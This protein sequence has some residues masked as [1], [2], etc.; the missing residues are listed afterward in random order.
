MSRK[1][2]MVKGQMA[3]IEQ[4]KLRLSSY[5]DK[6]WV[7]PDW[8]HTELCEFHM[9]WAGGSCVFVETT[10]SSSPFPDKATFRAMV[11]IIDDRLARFGYSMS[12]HNVGSVALLIP[13]LS[14]PSWLR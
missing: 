7:L 10:N 13:P 2:R 14:S 9:L 8:I 6:H 3:T 1:K 4:Q 11:Q 12:K 5:Y